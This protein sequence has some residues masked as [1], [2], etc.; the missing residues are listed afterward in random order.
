[1]KI[2]VHVIDHAASR[3]AA[4]CQ[5]L[6]ARSFHAEPYENV[7][8]FIQSGAYSGVAFAH[9]D[10]I[11][12]DGDTSKVVDLM[13][14]T[15]LPVAF[16][17]DA[18]ELDR[19]T[20]VMRAGAINVMNW[21]ISD[22]EIAGTFENLGSNSLTL[23]TELRERQRALKIVSSLSNREIEVLRHVVHGKSAKDAGREMGISPRT[24]EAHKF[25][26][27]SKMK[28]SSLPHAIRI[29]YY[30]GIGPVRAPAA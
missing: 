29:G 18:P 16:Y 6:L 28:A 22:L 12:A 20:A 10:L 21:P 3:R 19:V 25:K 8:E 23:S 24:V 1:M 9:L 5:L 4:L 30:A 11:Q 14:A 2:T 17:A 7:H 15:N 27:F 26:A 13:T